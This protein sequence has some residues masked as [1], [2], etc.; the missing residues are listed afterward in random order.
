MLK[1][2]A[3]GCLCLVLAV[4]GSGCVESKNVVTLNP[5]GKGKIQ[6]DMLM[7]AVADI[8]AVAPGGVKDES[9]E[10]MKRSSVAKLLTDAKG[11][12]AWKDVSAEWKEDGRLH[13][14]ATAYFDKLEKVKVDPVPMSEFKV[15]SEKGVLKITQ[16]ISTNSE[17]NPATAPP[18]PT[19]DPK[20]LS[21]KEL[22]EELLKMRIQYQSAR[23]MFLAMFHDFKGTTTINLPGK[24]G[25]MKGFKKQGDTVV[26]HE[27]KGGDLLKALDGF[28]AKD[29][30][31]LRKIVRDAGTLKPFE[32]KD[33]PFPP[34]M[35]PESATASLTVKDATKD[36]FDYDKEM[37]QA[38]EG[39]ADLRDKFKID[40]KQKWPW[41]KPGKTEV[42]KP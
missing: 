29:N 2:V 36:L 5:D 23:P 8:G 10:G 25:D 35:L 4:L 33:A 9:P 15:V 30:A 34:D 40:S 24:A 27:L 14:M 18:K 37:K 26:V 11:V 31:A 16:S 17:A 20:K 1:R 22:D 13:F 19:P 28:M 21:D 32:S 3:P 38:R 6:L 12:T 41:E 39:S 7:P 42:P